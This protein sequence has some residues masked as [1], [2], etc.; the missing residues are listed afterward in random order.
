MLQQLKYFIQDLKRITNKSLLRIVTL[1]FLR[2][3]WGIGLYRIDRGFYLLIGKHYNIVRLIFMPIYNF[4]QALANIEIHYKADIK[5]GFMILHPA[6]GVV[7]SRYSIIGNNFT[8][9]GGNV[10]GAKPGC[11]HNE[12]IIGN[13]CSMG[14]NATLIGPL[15]ISNNIVIGASACV[16]NDC[17]VDD[18]ILVGIPAK[19]I[20]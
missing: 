4:I 18:S 11:Q 20:N 6:V 5:G 9:T 3:V 19:R 16:V 15:K 14:A 12:I 8:M 1:P 2:Q 7:I 13:F 10:I 17:L